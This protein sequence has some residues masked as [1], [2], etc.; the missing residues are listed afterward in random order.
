M[1]NRERVQQAVLQ[2][3][4]AFFRQQDSLQFLPAQELHAGCKDG[5][6][7]EMI[8]SLRRQLA[9]KAGFL[10]A[11]A[12]ALPL[13]RPEEANLRDTFQSMQL[14]QN[15]AGEQLR[16]ECGPLAGPSLN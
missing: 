11:R 13:M 10:V 16:L 12:H 8:E 2:D 5:S 7:R 14:L 6:L 4:E 15:T 3:K 9:E 1:E